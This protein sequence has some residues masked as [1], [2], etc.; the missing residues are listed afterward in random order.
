MQP[1]QRP[2][3]SPWRGLGA[4]ALLV[5]AGAHLSLVPEHLREAPYVGV[6]FLAL[7]VVSIVLAGLVVARDRPLVWVTSGTVSLLAMAGFLVS[8]TVG[9]PEL[10]DD[11]GNWTEPLGFPALAAETVTVVL[12]ILVLRR[13]TLGRT[14]PAA[15]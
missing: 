12:T 4:V 2:L 14:T 15:P 1:S 6:L 13:A 8:R 10:G 7:S 9:L 5:T 11:I 3:R